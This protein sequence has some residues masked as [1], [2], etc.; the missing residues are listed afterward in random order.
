[1]IVV[2]GEALIDLVPSADRHSYV[3]RPGGSPT[4][5]AV[6]LGRLGVEVAML[7]RLARDPLG[8]VLR[9]HLVSSGVDL[10]LAVH[11]EKP[12]SLALASLDTAGSARYTFY[13][14]GTAEG[15]WRADTLPPHL[16]PSTA[17]HV[18]GSLALAVSGLGEAV[19]TLLQRERPRLTLTLDP[20]LRPSL[21][22]DEVA[23]RGR[24]DRWL[25]LVDI[26]K[27][28]SEDLEWLEPGVPVQDLAQRWRARGAALVVVTRGQQGVFALGPGG[29]IDLPARVVDLVDTV[30]AGDAFM[31][32]LLAG[33][34]DLDRLD[35]QRLA[36]LGPAELGAVLELAQD[37]AAYTCGREGADPPWWQDR[38]PVIAA[39]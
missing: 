10:S 32:G 34:Q 13:I 7:A 28:S 39:G 15:G 38:K 31:S 2:C 18:S 14:D 12:T 6:G 23:L 27:V 9:G 3:P 36:G 17:L 30:G 11:S 19:D 26:V 5:V 37:V 21:V 4:N 24:L 20:N 8:L 22:S 33:L 35:R 16:P 25:G 29:A 1:M